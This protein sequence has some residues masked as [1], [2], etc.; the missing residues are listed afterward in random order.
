MKEK[1]EDGCIIYGMYLEGCKYD[2]KTHKLEESDP[3]KLF[4]DIPLMLLVP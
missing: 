3:K 2:N 4:T 1:P